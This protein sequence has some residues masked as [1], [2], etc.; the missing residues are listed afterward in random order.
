MSRTKMPYW[1]KGG[2]YGILFGAALYALSAILLL[3]AFIAMPAVIFDFHL[4]L[5]G[6]I[7]AWFVLLTGADPVAGFVITIILF[8]FIL[9]AII[10]MIY[11]RIRNGKIPKTQRH[12]KD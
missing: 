9:G 10:A 11:E 12:V 4:S 6:K 2:L 5:L 1:V 7:A 8:Y 3:T